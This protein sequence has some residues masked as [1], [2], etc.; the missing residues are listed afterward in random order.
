[1]KLPSETSGSTRQELNSIAHRCA[2]IF[3]AFLIGPVSAAA[4][5]IGPNGSIARCGDGLYAFSDMGQRTCE[6]HGGVKEWFRKGATVGSGPNGA[7]ARCGSGGV[8]F[9]DKGSQTCAGFGGVVEWFRPM[10][11]PKVEPTAQDSSSVE[12]PATN[13]AKMA[14][15]ANATKQGPNGAVARCVSGGYIFTPTGDQTCAKF[16]GVAEWYVP[17]NE[18]SNR[19]PSLTASRAPSRWQGVLEGILAFSAG[20]LAGLNAGTVPNDYVGQ[21][22]IMV[23]SDNN[24][25]LGCLSCDEFARDSLFNEF[26]LFGNKFNRDSIL[27]NFGEYGSPYSNTSACNKFATKPPKVVDGAGNFYGYLTTNTLHAKRVEHPGILAWL[28][29]V[30]AD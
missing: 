30:C 8:V 12:V 15:D 13:A 19:T 6:G 16:G 14:P 25:Y 17:A 28:A 20:A 21:S 7:I 5:G 18:R 22:K 3:A 27:N 1:M 29:S 4:Q 24:N 11:A 26:G 9:E 23:F 10:T 2:I